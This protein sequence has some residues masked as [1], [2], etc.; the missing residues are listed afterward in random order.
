MRTLVFFDG[1]GCV[2]KEA[3]K[4]GDDV[5]ANDILPLGHIDLPMD[6]MD[7]NPKILGDWIPDRLHFSPPCE[8]YSIIT[9]RKGGGNLYYQTVKKNGKV[10]G[11][12]PREDFHSD[13]RFK[14]LTDEE[15][16]ALKIKVRTKQAQHL[17]FLKKTVEIIKYYSKINP[18]L[19]WIIENPASGLMRHQLKGMIENMVENKTTYCMY[20]CEYR[21]ETS[22]FS[23]VKMNLKYCRKHRKG[24][25]DDCGGHLDNLVQRHDHK[26]QKKGVVKT[27][28]Y[29]EKSH[30]PSGLCKDILTQSESVFK[31]S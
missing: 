11:L 5:K 25:V 10:V 9:A 1:L 12:F 6:I 16:K 21:K 7:F 26:R 8:T 2:S 14:K 31:T 24:V 4:L 22:I 20:G 19:V 13:K 15:R 23:N 27:R 3:K 28:S 30:I 17:E 29:L 18:N